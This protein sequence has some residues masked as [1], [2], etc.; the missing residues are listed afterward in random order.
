MTSRRALSLAEVIVAIWCLTFAC[1]FCLGMINSGNQVYLK[2][3]ENTRRENLAQQLIERCAG[4]EYDEVATVSGSFAG[5]YT[6]A[7]DVDQPDIPIL[8]P[9]P[10]VVS[11][12]IC[13]NSK[14]LKVTV[15]S[16]DGRS[17][18][19][20]GGRS[21]EAALDGLTLYTN[22]YGCVG[23][24]SLQYGSGPTQISSGTFAPPHT[25]LKKRIMTERLTPPRGANSNAPADMA[26]AATYIKESISTPA[27]YVVYSWEPLMGGEPAITDMSPAEQT[28]LAN[29][30]L[31]VTAGDDCPPLPHA[32]TLPIAA[33]IA[34]LKAVLLNF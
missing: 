29:W 19:L 8:G 4:L 20:W 6:Y 34:I 31:T 22:K 30:L 21:K 26:D 27:A 2:T 9:S 13:Q 5:G 28:A 1:L 23:C 14:R 16:S 33:R 15:T 17:T 25:G 11:H 10:G 12:S 32:P 3:Q 7:V 24:H 18:V